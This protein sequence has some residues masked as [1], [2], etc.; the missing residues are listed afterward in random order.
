VIRKAVQLAV[1]GM[2]LVGR[3][4]LRKIATAFLRSPQEEKSLVWVVVSCG[5]R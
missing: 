4:E 1:R 5:G 3:K 2:L